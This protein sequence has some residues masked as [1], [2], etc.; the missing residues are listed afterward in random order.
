MLTNTKYRRIMRVLL[1]ISVV[2]KVKRGGESTTMGLV[3][4]LSHHADV[5]VFSGGPFAHDETTDLAFPDLPRYASIYNR[6]PSFLKHRIVRRLHLDPL[7]VRN[8]FFCLRVIAR[9]RKNPSYFDLVIFRSVGP[10]GA[11]T[12]R[13]LRKKYGIPF[14]TIEGGWKTGEREVA[15]YSPNLHIS[16]NLDVADYLKKQLPDVKI[17]YIPNGISVRDFDQKG[18]K[19]KVDLPR[20]LFLGCGALDDF[21][22][23]HL[24]IKAVH[25]LG[26]GS[27]LL[28]GKGPE[29]TSLQRFGERK[30][31]N[32]FLLTSVPYDEM[33]CF[34]R[35]ADLVTV[36]SSGESFGMVYLEAMAC[37]KPIVATNDRNREFIIGECGLLVDPEDIDAY[38]EAL[39]RTY[40]IDYAEK[41]RH[42][43]ER[44]EWEVIGPEYLKA[45]EQVIKDSKDS[46]RHYPIYRRMGRRE[47]AR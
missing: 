13:Y 37:N 36:P 27:L 26:K 29:E 28:L 20:P 22:R 46:S 32:R 6:L 47:K 4:F 33:P 38:A 24:T 11:K 31:K 19:A 14:V 42:Q 5:H 23:F 17:A 40:K 10:W 15:R 39:D 8:F 30:L 12:G 9:F 35:A 45:F 18:K 1:V 25:S 41:P 3:S 2:G 34:Y 21:K 16:V 43:A 44:F 7:S